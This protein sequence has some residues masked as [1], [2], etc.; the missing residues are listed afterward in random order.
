MGVDCLWELTK[1][2][3]DL[4][5]GCLQGGYADLLAYSVERERLIVWQVPEAR[6]RRCEGRACQRAG[7]TSQKVFAKLFCQSH[8][9]HKSVNLFFILVVIKK[10]LT[11]FLWKLTFVF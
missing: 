1:E 7:F 4:P 3:V 8:F 9:P 2:T 11:I 5:R 10:E 6:E